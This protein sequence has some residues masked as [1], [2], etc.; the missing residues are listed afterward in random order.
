LRKIL[1]ILDGLSDKIE[2]G[3]K[4]S[5]E[6]AYTPNL[7]YMASQGMCGM[8]WPIKGI[9]PESG[10]S[11]FNILG[12]DLRKY[13]GRGVIEALGFHKGTK[14]GARDLAL[15]CNFA[16]VWHQRIFNLRAEIP[17]TSVMSKLNKIDAGI[18]IIPTIGYRGIMIVKNAGTTN[19]SNTHPGYE[20]YKNFSRAVDGRMVE[21]RCKGDKKV[22][23]KINNFLSKAEKI[24]GM[25]KTILIRDGG[26]GKN[27]P[28]L[29][30]MKDWYFV[31][32]M[33][34]EYGLARLFGMKMLKKGGDEIGR[35]CSVKGNVYVQ[36][37][38]PDTFGHRGDKKG[39]IKAIELADRMLGPLVKLKGK[40]LVCIT[41]DHSTPPELKRH[42]SDPVP[43][44]V[45][46]G[47]K[48]DETA[49][50]SE[51]ACSKGKLG[52]FTG[53]HLMKKLDELK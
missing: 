47:K 27:I 6:L 2:Q 13:P 39:K 23:E 37:K 33:P 20:K 29:R 50:F 22:C 4:T 28:K 32:D 31:G 36:I 9:A 10:S 18:R 17:K 14:L 25:K 35:I 1:I 49:E 19:V 21:K 53:T 15:R 38:G 51:R 44:L 26:L 46:G 24:M 3:K 11:Q 52:K 41:S 34:V 48:R 5:L 40:A 8:M 16:R 43:V 12:G 30:K 7:D 45:Y 42:S